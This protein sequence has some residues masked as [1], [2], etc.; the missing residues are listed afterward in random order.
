MEVKEQ[1]MSRSRSFRVFR[2]AMLV[3]VAYAAHAVSQNTK[4]GNPPA[5][6]QVTPPITATTPN[7]GPSPASRTAPPTKSALPENDVEQMTR[8]QFRALADNAL[9]RYH[10]QSVTKAAFVKQRLK[11]RLEQFQAPGRQ[12]P[13]ASFE[14]LRSQ[15]LQNRAADL[16]TRNARAQAMGD[17]LNS[18]M[19][20]VQSSPAYASLLKETA[21]IQRQYRTAS[22]AEQLR[23]KQ[24]A[25]EIH[26][27]LLKL[28]SN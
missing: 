23:F 16:A 14:A 18:R 2:Q 28:E 11:Q 27:E 25:L 21:E 10:G 26:T 19:A 20:Q 15:F 24:R 8:A 22:P 6:H 4:T 1:L 7:A 17:A 3:L 12:K 9:V 13:D 5:Q